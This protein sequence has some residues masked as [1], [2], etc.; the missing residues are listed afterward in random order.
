MQGRLIRLNSL[1]ISI[2]VRMASFCLHSL[3][4]FIDNIQGA[5]TEKF[6]LFPVAI[7]Y[8]ARNF[9]L[10]FGF[11]P[12]LQYMHFFLAHLLQAVPLQLMMEYRR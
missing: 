2:A 9:F 4:C 11:L 6:G 8:N 12:V 10:L 3:V 5:L 7:M 1:K